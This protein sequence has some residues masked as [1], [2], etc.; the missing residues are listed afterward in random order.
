MDGKKRGEDTFQKIVRTT[1]E[2]G[3]ISS[4]AS[5]STWTISA[6]KTAL[7]TGAFGSSASW[8]NMPTAGVFI[9]SATAKKRNGDKIPTVKATRRNSCQGGLLSLHATQTIIQQRRTPLAQV[10]R[11]QKNGHLAGKRR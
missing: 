1:V 5:L 6:D 9:G 8:R 11:Q 10:L 3:I 4:M 2:N 7:V